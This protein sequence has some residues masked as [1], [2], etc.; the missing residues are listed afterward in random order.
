MHVTALTC[1][2]C[3]ATYASDAIRYECD[4]GGSVDV[5]YDYDEI[6][7]TVTWDRLRNRSLDHYRY[8]ELLPVVRSEHRIS[9][10][11][12]GTPLVP[13]T[14]IGPDLGIN[15]YF[16]LEG[17]NPTGSFKDRGTS[18]ELGKAMDFGADTVVAASTG[19]M[20]ASIAAYAA[21]AGVDA[22]IYVP[23]QTQGPKLKQ[24][25]SHGATLVEVDG[26]YSVAA[27]QAWNAYEENG[28]YLMGDYPYRG[29]GQKTVGYEI[30]DQLGGVDTVVAP[31]G[32][33][34]LIHAVWK[35]FTELARIGLS[36]DVPRL[37]GVQAAG[38][39]TV[40]DALHKGFSDIRP[41]QDVDTVAGAIACG[42]PL[43]GDQALHALQ[44]SDGYGVA[45]S[46][47]DILDAKQVLAEQEGI[48]A[49]EAGAAGIA[50][51]LNDPD[52]F[53]DGETVV[54]LVTG[55]GLKT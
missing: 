47:E 33:G 22:T 42:D 13:S 35:G 27:A 30:A 12:G 32:N 15:L 50:G 14:V 45:V 24:M 19:N 38:C 34:T 31:V 51:M 5:T 23:A 4:C 28:T 8:R 25:Q 26:D 43:D 55:H 7:G 10:G 6:R 36:D 17:L 46:D 16:K 9:M 49:E 44:E 54:C 39:N 11:A 48:Y 20:G 29:E 40:V 21:R 1:V 41:V 18:V 53:E 52:R 3:G 2:Q 37:A